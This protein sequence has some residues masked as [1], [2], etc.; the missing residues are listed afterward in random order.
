MERRRLIWLV[1]TL[2]V[3][4]GTALVTYTLALQLP[5][6]MAPGDL[7]TAHQDVDCLR[8]HRAYSGVQDD[9][10]LDCHE[11]V[12]D[13]VWH[14]EA[15][16]GENC[17]DCHYEH[18]ERDY[19]TDLTQVPPHPDR[20]IELTG[21]HTPLRCNECHW[22]AATPSECAD[23]H[24]RY[25]GGTHLVGFTDQ[26]DLCH[27]QG[28]DWEVDY[29]HD[30][31]EAECVDCHGND[32]DH[33]YP[34]YLEFDPTCEACHAVDLWLMPV[35]DHEAI[36]VSNVSCQLCHPSSL[37]LTYGSRSADCD[38]C[39]LNASWTPQVIDHE[40]LDPPCLRCHE[41]DLPTEHLDENQY[42]PLDCE[43]CHEP[44]VSWQRMVDHENHTQPCIQ[45]HGGSADLHGLVYADDCQWCHVTD[46]RDILLPHPPQSEDCT[47]C[48]VNQHEGGDP[49]A[50]VD[51]SHAALCG[52]CH[53]AGEDWNISAQD[54]DLLGRDC[55]ACHEPAHAAIGGREVGCAVCHDTEYWLPTVVD[56]DLMGEDCAACHVTTHPNGKDQF[57]E[58]CNLCHVTDDWSE[59]TWDHDLANESAIEC[60]KCHD[61]IHLGTLGLICEDCHT[62]D[63]WE[64]EVINP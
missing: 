40:R 54:H 32:Q 48:H 52:A 47:K 62:T 39:H 31:E 19:I 18:V 15:G 11:D 5:E 14:T 41:G 57:S 35:F 55:A 46:R 43:A 34:G 60:V 63:T 59:R 49:V 53:L 33:L 50:S 1:I 29:D 27:D 37:D 25:I 8:C 17:V 61:D 12:K 22:T 51:A 26:C 36:N 56:H 13:K 6:E 28:T 7:S 20:D 64:T 24:D 58:Q 38:D 44:G 23:C 9:L 21:V 30:L 42:T 10:C 3:V 16:G 2:A 45:C 4:A